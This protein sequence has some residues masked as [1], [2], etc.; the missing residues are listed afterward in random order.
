MRCLYHRRGTSPEKAR[1]QVA[2]WVRVPRGTHSL[3]QGE[4]R[5]ISNFSGRT[6]S[7]NPA[8]GFGLSKLPSLPGFSLSGFSFGVQRASGDF[9]DVLP[10]G[11]DA[12]LLVVADVMGHGEPA[13]PFA[14][15]LRK[16]IRA[17]AQSEASPAQLLTQ[18]NQSM[19][20]QL[21][22]ADTFITAQVA[23]VDAGRR[24]LTVASA[25]HCPLLLAGPCGQVNSI[26]PEGMPLGILPDVSFAQQVLPLDGSCRVCLYTDGLT[27][28]RNSKGHL[29]G[30]DRLAACLSQSVAGAQT[31]EETC[32]GFLAELDTFRSQG[33]PQDDQTLLILAEESNST[34][35][36]PDSIIDVSREVGLGQSSVQ[37]EAAQEEWLRAA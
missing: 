8:Q 3:G 10:A 23:L 7:L 11:D 25:G 1:Q 30:S 18:V 6:N 34:A 28:A 22:R 4:V 29:F 9:F 13:A 24:R 12:L 32:H 21:S 16:C 19:F 26:S 20:E 15:S 35:L 37:V 2:P 36:L 33:R 27:E 5:S 31:A 17:L 14:A